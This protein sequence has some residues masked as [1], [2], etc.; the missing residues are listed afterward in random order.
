MEPINIQGVSDLLR[1]LYPGRGSTEALRRAS[2]L[3]KEGNL[4]E[5]ACFARLAADLA[6]EETALPSSTACC[7]IEQ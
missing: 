3:L 4:V 5:A 7:L 1:E 2:Q 6:E